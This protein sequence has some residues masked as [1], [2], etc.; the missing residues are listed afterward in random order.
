MRRFNLAIDGSR[1]GGG[2]YPCCPRRFGLPLLD[3]EIT[4]DVNTP[5][6]ARVATIAREAM[7]DSVPKGVV[8]EWE[9][10]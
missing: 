5:D 3:Q 6:L 1:P 8:Y 4:G 7:F 10:A 9:E 2:S